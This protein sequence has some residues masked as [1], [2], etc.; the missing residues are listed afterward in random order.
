MMGEPLKSLWAVT[1][2]LCTPSEDVRRIS[3]TIKNIEQS[4]NARKIGQLGDG[5]AT[6]L[7]TIVQQGPGANDAL[8]KQMEIYFEVIEI[9][10]KTFMRD[11]RIALLVGIRVFEEL[12][13]NTLTLGRER[14]FEAIK[15]IPNVLETYH[16]N[17]FAQIDLLE[18][19]KNLE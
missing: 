8:L 6:M 11:L 7:E 2:G 1:S 16:A 13:G 10:S 3:N 4:E 9:A 15:S 18:S 12:E 5:L 19:R 14:L 17:L